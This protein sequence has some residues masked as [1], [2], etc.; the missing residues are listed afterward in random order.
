MQRRPGKSAGSQA[1]RP[2]ARLLV[3][4]CH[5]AWVSQLGSLDYDLDIILDLPGRA[6]TGWDANMRPFPRRARALTL[7]EAKA[8]GG[9][10]HAIIANNITD[11]L[12]AWSPGP[13]S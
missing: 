11:L 2:P 7:D 10:W 8:Q 4:N 12:D 1:A 6:V 3:F 9:G 5:E 13:R